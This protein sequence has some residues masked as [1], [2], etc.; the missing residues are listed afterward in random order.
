MLESWTLRAL[1]ALDSRHPST[2]AKGTTKA[3][4][5]VMGM[6]DRGSVISP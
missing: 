2:G 3:V 5:W 4:T 1:E 6:G